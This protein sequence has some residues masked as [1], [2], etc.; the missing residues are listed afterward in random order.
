[1]KYKVIEMSIHWDDTKQKFVT[2]TIDE[3]N[4]KTFPADKSNADYVQFL[5]QAKLTDKQVQAAKTDTWI[6]L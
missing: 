6:T 2:V 4:Y 3:E 1:M 5:E